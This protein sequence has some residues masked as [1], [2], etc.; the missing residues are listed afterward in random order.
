VK[1]LSAPVSPIPAAFFVGDDDDDDKPT[2]PLLLLQ[3]DLALP[4]PM[5]PLP[6]FPLKIGRNC[7]LIESSCL[8][9]S[10]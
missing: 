4:M 5:T 3:K 8:C 10:P 2:T 1:R 7:R 9:P 6:P